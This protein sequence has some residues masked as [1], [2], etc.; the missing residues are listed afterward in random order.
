MGLFADYLEECRER[1]EAGDIDPCMILSKKRI[2]NYRYAHI[3]HALDAYSGAAE[4]QARHSFALALEAHWHELDEA[5]QQ[6]IACEKFILSILA[7]NNWLSSFVYDDLQELRDQLYETQRCIGE[8]A[9]GIRKRLNKPSIIS[10]DLPHNKDACENLIHLMLS[11]AI[12]SLKNGAPMDVPMFRNVVKDL[13]VLVGQQSGC[14]S[15]ST[16]KG[17]VG[18]Y[19]EEQLHARVGKHVCENCGQLL[20]NDIPY[21]LNCYERNGN[22]DN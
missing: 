11:S 1:M 4:E 5:Q 9:A 13:A 10:A 6:Y 15:A 12:E 21:C 3:R 17:M 18:A 22:N 14:K 19:I 8:A 2:P 16:A 7:N 20:Y